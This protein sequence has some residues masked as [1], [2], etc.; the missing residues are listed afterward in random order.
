MIA[1]LLKK[2]PYL[3]S[4]LKDIKNNLVS[5]KSQFKYWDFYYKTSLFTLI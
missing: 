4:W 1:S 2:D 5:K 3:Y